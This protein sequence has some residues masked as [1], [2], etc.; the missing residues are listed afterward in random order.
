METLVLLSPDSDPVEEDSTVSTRTGSGNS[1]MSVS[2]AGFS[3]EDALL[4]DVKDAIAVS[5]ADDSSPT[6]SFL[7]SL[8]DDEDESEED[9]SSSTG[10]RSC[11]FSLEAENVGDVKEAIADSSSSSESERA[12]HRDPGESRGFL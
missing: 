8:S 4:G 7:L 9:S 3:F 11:R 5:R 10:A 6:D 1:L 12:E 2:G